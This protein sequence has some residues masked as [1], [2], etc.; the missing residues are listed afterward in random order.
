MQRL[1]FPAFVEAIG[2][3]EQRTKYIHS[4]LAFG[5]AERARLLPTSTCAQAGMSGVLFNHGGGWMWMVQ[6]RQ[7]LNYH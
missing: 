2:M 5:A 7:A 6:R 1:A 4:L 3:I